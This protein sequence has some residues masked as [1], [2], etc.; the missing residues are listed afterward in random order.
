MTRSRTAQPGSE[1]ASDASV[2]GEAT[3]VSKTPGLNRRRFCGAAVATIAAGPLGLL[4][5]DRRFNTMTAALAEGAQPAA[6]DQT[7]IRPFYVNF[8]DAD[9]ADLRRRINA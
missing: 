8:P 4:D 9:L 3:R 5:F 1:H 7:D 6:S 2:A